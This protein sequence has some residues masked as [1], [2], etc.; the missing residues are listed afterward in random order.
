LAPAW[1]RL[2]APSRSV[3]SALLDGYVRTSAATTA[4]LQTVKPVQP[5]DS[6]TAL[7]HAPGL[8]AVAT[9]V[10]TGAYAEALAAPV[11]PTSSSDWTALST[12]CATPP[13]ADR[14]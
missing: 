6:F 9:V 4:D 14:R 1:N 2:A 12:A 10:A 13:A 8:S 5:S 7:L 11:G 3:S